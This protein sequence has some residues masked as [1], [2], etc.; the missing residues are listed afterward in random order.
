MAGYSPATAGVCASRET[1]A[2]GYNQVST[3]SF[4]HDQKKTVEHIVAAMVNT[5]VVHGANAPSFVRQ[6]NR[7]HVGEVDLVENTAQIA[8]DLLR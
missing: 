4:L 3:I 8:F 7:L 1:V 5:S 2:P 6:T